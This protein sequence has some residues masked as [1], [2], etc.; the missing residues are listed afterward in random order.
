[1]RASM[2]SLFAVPLAPAPPPGLRRVALDAGAELT[3]AEVDL[4]GPT[5]L[6]LGAEREGLSAEAVAGADVACQIPQTDA[7]DSLNVAMAA[8]IALYEVARQR[9]LAGISA[10][11]GSATRSR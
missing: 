9:A 1:V 11:P 4:T 2:G 7:I 10:R 3:L 6:V 5:C 8:T